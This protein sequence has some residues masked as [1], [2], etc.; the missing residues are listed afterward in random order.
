MDANAIKLN[1][2][3]AE[4]CTYRIGGPAKC[5]FCAASE[6]EVAAGLEVARE[7]NFP[8]FI[9]GGGSNVLFSDEGFPGLVLKMEN[10]S[11]EA[12]EEGDKTNLIVGAGTPL[13]ALAKFALDHS[14]AGMEWAAGIPGTVGGAIR[15]NAGAFHREMGEAVAKVRALRVMP[16]GLESR[17]FQKSECDFSYRDS[18]F[19]RDKNLVVVSAA[20][21]LTKGDQ[22]GIKAEMDE[23]LTKKAT[24]QPLEH[25]SAGSVFAN[26]AGFFAGKLIEDCGFKGK[27][28][29]GA[30]VSEKHA[31]FIINRGN[32]TASEVKELIS[33]IKAAAKEKFGVEMKEEI[34]VI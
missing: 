11:I 31:N 19:K 5:Y 25:P 29:G 17:I 1:E 26:P 22:A 23:Y 7:N 2:V 3:L 28:I 14:L 34:E 21:S 24:T 27:I 33:Q 6:D 13:A 12:R 4:H 9:L 20:L 32:A 16:D 18:I 10:N 30:Q 8:F 15:G